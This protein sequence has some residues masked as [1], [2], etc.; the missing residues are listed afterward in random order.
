MSE[1]SI[2]VTLVGVHLI[3]LMSPGPDVALVMQSASRYGRKTGVLIAAGLT[4]GI[5][6]HLAFTLS[7]ISLLIQ[8]Q[9]L[10]FAVLQLI[11]GSYL[12]YLGIG[13]LKATIANWKLPPQL[14]TNAGA[15]LESKRQ[16]FSKGFMT[17]IL[18]PKA[19]VFFISLLSSFIP[20]GMSVL[21]K[22]SVVA[23]IGGVSF[24][25]F[26]SLAWLLTT[27]AMQKRL[28]GLTRY[29]DATCGVVFVLA[30]ATIILQALS[31]M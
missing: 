22:V 8:K 4:C 31:H 14:A 29:I 2:L 6:L 7:G 17:N 13:A 16:A 26:A 20:V 1:I 23:L 5:F 28:V 25:W 24:L 21:G 19:F 18:N 3:G 10:I 9:P 27:S 11:G 30:G 12:F 15:Q